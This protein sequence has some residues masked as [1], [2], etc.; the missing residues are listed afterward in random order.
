MHVQQCNRKQCRADRTA[1]AVQATAG[2]L[3]LRPRY[4]MAA[5]DA[6]PQPPDFPAFARGVA[7]AA[8]SGGRILTDQAR[9]AVPPFA[10]MPQRTLCVPALPAHVCML[11]AGWRRRLL[12]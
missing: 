9:T 7:T 1:S 12:S 5:V 3:G 6:A 8:A 4:R 11:D 2:R 10:L